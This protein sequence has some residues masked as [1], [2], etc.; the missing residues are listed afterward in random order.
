VTG[1]D[2]RLRAGAQGFSEQVIVK[3]REAAADPKLAQVR[4][5][6]SIQGGGSLRADRDGDVDFVDSAG[7]SLRRRP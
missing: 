5:T 7:A 4:F 1:V 6:A 2:L 3:T